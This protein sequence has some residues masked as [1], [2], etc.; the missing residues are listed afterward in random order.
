MNKQFLLSVVVAFIVSMVLGFVV[1][2]LLLK[3]D[4]ASVSRLMRSVDDT[5]RHFPAMLV[6]H[7]IMAIG[8]TA[9]YRR[10]REAGKGCLGQGIR[11]GIWLALAACVPGFLIYYTVQPLGLSL[12]VKQIVFGGIAT[13]LL[14]IAVA[15]VNKPAV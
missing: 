13:V 1:H 6:A 2:D 15:A 4:Y 12:V 7:A 3:N 9:I 8:V 14:G 5:K 11:F 10:G